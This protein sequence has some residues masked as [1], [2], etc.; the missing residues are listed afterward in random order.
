MMMAV[1]QGNIIAVRVLLEAGAGGT[2]TLVH[3]TIACLR[4]R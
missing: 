3:A 1:T 2:S 4:L